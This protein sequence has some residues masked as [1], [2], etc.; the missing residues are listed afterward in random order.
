VFSQR[1]LRLGAFLQFSN[2]KRKQRGCAKF[3]EEAASDF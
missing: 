2:R 3:A 1:T